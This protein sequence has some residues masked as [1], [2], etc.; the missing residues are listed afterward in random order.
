MSLFSSSCLVCIECRFVYVRH[1]NDRCYICKW[2]VC[3]LITR[4]KTNWRRLIPPWLFTFSLLVCLSGWLNTTMM[5]LLHCHI[6]F[7]LIPLVCVCLLLNAALSFSFDSFCLC[8][9]LAIFPPLITP[10]TDFSAKWAQKLN[11]QILLSESQ[12]LNAGRSEVE[13]VI[14]KT[15]KERIR[16]LIN[17]DVEDTKTT[18]TK[19]ALPHRAC[20]NESRPWVKIGSVF[21]TLRNTCTISTWCVVEPGIWSIFIQ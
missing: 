11:A 10:E 18:Q 14:L 20:V 15:I 1:L 4:P 5:F 16:G 3:H 6:W 9:S 17:T 8:L 2:T 21:L 13:Q 12:A 7:P 19:N